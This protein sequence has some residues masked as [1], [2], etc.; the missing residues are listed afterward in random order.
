MH[1]MDLTVSEYQLLYGRFHLY[2]SPFLTYDAC[3]VWVYIL[4]F[5]TQIFS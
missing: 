3:K 1:T 5:E 4:C 2:N